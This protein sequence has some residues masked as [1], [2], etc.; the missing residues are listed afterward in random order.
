[1]FAR[2]R[3]HDLKGAYERRGAL[4]ASDPCTGHSRQWDV[5]S[6]TISETT[7]YGPSTTTTLTVT[8]RH[9]APGYNTHSRVAAQRPREAVG[10]LFCSRCGAPMDPGLIY[11]GFRA[12]PRSSRTA[13]A[14]PHGCPRSKWWWSAGWV[15]WMATVSV[16]PVIQMHVLV[17]GAT[18]GDRFLGTGT[19]D[20]WTPPEEDAT[21][22][23]LEDDHLGRNCDGSRA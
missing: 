17:G 3:R 9:R 20:G 16:P 5:D 13:M 14:V 6:R 1:M 2:A 22:S 21:G 15:E 12:S 4:E 18:Y 23:G 19:R 11:A 7:R 10:R 8:A